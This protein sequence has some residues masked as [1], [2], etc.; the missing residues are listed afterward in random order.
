VQGAAARARELRA[1]GYLRSLERAPQR[2]ELRSPAQLGVDIRSPAL[3]QANPLAD[4]AGYPEAQR[5][6]TGSS[7]VRAMDLPV[8]SWREIRRH[9]GA[10][11]TWIVIDG[12]VYDVS[13][14]LEQH[15]GGAGRLKEWAGRDASG[16]FREA[17]HSRL[18]HVFRLNYRIGRVL[19]PE[20]LA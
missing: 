18:T 5:P 2:G 10:D 3:P 13:D 19:E 12:E 11:S 16:A 20:P 14:W 8:Y 9:E 15:P 6:I 17:A 7:D 1:A 4:N